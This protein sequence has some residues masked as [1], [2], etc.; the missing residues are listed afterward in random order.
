MQSILCVDPRCPRGSLVPYKSE[1]N[2]FHLVLAS[3]GLGAPMIPPDIED[4]PKGEYCTIKC[5][6][7][8]VY[9]NILKGA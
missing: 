2:Q 6:D 3:L 4:K 7:L 9:K 8:E 1:E 5:S